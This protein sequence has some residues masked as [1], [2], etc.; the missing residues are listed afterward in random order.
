MVGRHA[1][2]DAAGAGVVHLGEEVHERGLG[3]FGAVEHLVGAAA[4]VFTHE[5]FEV[6]ARHQQVDVVVPGN[7]AFVAHRAEQRAVGHRI[8][9][10]LFAAEGVHVAQDIQQ[11]HLYFAALQRLS[12]HASHAFQVEQHL[13]LFFGG[14][15]VKR[16]E[17]DELACGVGVER[18]YLAVH[19][20]GLAAAFEIAHGVALFLQ[21]QPTFGGHAQIEG[22]LGLEL[23]HVAELVAEVVLHHIRPL[24]GPFGIPALEQRM[25][26]V[27][28]KHET[29]AAAHHLQGPQ[30]R[31]LE[32]YVPGLK[33]TEQP[34]EPGR[35]PAAV[36]NHLA[37]TKEVFRLHGAHE[38]KVVVE[39]DEV[40][41]EVGNVPDESVDGIGI[42]HRKI[43]FPAPENY[44]MVNS[45][46]IAHALRKMLFQH[47]AQSRILAVGDDENLADPRRITQDGS[48]AVAQLPDLLV[49]GGASRFVIGS[50]AACCEGGSAGREDR[51]ASVHPG[52]NCV[53]REGRG[54]IIFW[55][56]SGIRT[57]MMEPSIAGL[58]QA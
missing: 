47:I 56:R 50:F 30:H 19:V 39:V 31:S 51:I 43:L 14:A 26:G 21:Y 34:H 46:D 37:V 17:A 29:P 23:Q 16:I 11:P 12:T 24:F 58:F 4:A 45:H 10:T 57:T 44:L 28:H 40:L 1:R 5:A 32:S 48:Y 36:R 35:A 9:Q 27:H 20:A 7:E 52:N 49:S 13:F 6:G 54:H 22:L 33:G 41:R 3:R 53:Y 2:L 25:R 38:H 18:S 15:V 42:E 55:K 8:T